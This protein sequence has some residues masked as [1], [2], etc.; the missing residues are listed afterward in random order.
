MEKIVGDIEGIECY[1]DDILLHSINH[2]A[3]KELKEKVFRL[4]AEAGHMLNK[5]KCDSTAPA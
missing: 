4:I 5:S 2:P 1:Q 3:H